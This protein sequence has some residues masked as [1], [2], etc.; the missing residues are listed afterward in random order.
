M[1]SLKYETVRYSSGL[2]AKPIERRGHTRLQWK[3]TAS[4]RVLPTGQHLVGVLSDLSEAGC[5]IELGTPLRAELGSQIEVEL[6]LRGV[7]LRRTG[8]LRNLQVI[9]RLEQETRAGIEFIGETGA[10]DEQLRLLTKGF[11]LC[12]EKLKAA[13]AKSTPLRKLWTKLTG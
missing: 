7:T 6:H 11:H 12:D 3:G 13:L 5:G 4:L 9:R 2:T 10:S 1:S 8:I